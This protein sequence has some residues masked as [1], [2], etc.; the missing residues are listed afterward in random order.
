MAHHLR[1]GELWQRERH[2]P[3]EGGRDHR[4]GFFAAAHVA[5][6]TPGLLQLEEERLERRHLGHGTGLEADAVH[7]AATGRRAVIRSTAPTSASMSAGVVSSVHWIVTPS[8]QS[9]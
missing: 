6:G 2:A 7:D 1:F 9:V 3:P 5:A 8:P 4:V